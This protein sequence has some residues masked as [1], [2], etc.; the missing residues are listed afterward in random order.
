VG[1]GNPG[2]IPGSG[3]TTGQGRKMTSDGSLY[4]WA[5]WWQMNDDRF[6]NLRAHLAAAEITTDSSDDFMREVAVGEEGRTAIRPRARTE[7]EA[8]LRIAM[9]DPFFDAR[10]AAVIALGKVSTAA[11]PNE[12]L[13]LLGDEH[14]QVR[15][16][17]CLAIGLLGSKDAIPFLIEIMK[18]SA[19][20][21]KDI[22]KT[23]RELSVR[24]RA[25]A[26]LGI[27]LIG[28]RCDISDTSARESL[29]AMIAQKDA[30]QDLS[31]AP[32]VALGLMRDAAAVPHL[33]R[34]LDDE[35]AD[36][37]VRSYAATSLGK[38]GDRA[39]TVSL[40]KALMSKHN[41]VAQSAAIG[42]GALARPEDADAS[43]ALKRV[44]R[45]S[46]DIAARNFAVIALGE[47]GGK[48][49]RDF[50]MRL[51]DDKNRFLQTYAAI[52]LGI[53]GFRT[54]DPE[55]YM[56]AQ[57]LIT[58]FNTETN[59]EERGAFAVGL[60]LLRAIQAAPMLLTALERG[61]PAT[62]RAPLCTALGLLGHKPAI[63]EI[64]NVVRDRG[65]IELRR[66]AS[67][68]LGLLG[69]RNAVKILNEIM[70][71]STQS[72]AV[73]GAVTQGL[74]FI[75][76]AKA[77]PIL[78]GMAV[79]TAKQQAATR[80]FAAVALGLL[81]DKDQ[82]PLLTMISRDNNYLFPTE[83]IGEVLTIL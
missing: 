67:I 43:G 58:L 2:G 10:A 81:G 35:E 29:L 41:A 7:I 31:V 62:L 37:I 32:I 53:Y 15:E 66:E 17:S 34:L 14:Q 70:T 50:L 61:G 59:V 52:A 78:R 9:K 42:L 56:I 82:I 26:A 74:G 27:G 68:A 65:D 1:T 33:V 25:F 11:S 23:N 63:A 38:I 19:K 45:A 12:I 4:T 30:Q 80:A 5:K 22:A 13:A 73:H 60:G 24:T 76:D 48:E 71:E 64:E 44:V 55:E 21:R 8:A 28:A 69:D 51:L 6:L 36:A 79:D 3:G 40:V 46:T 18:D 49:N 54:E 83:S 57:R 16:S 39:A 77:I 47:I 72:Q 20:G 75:G